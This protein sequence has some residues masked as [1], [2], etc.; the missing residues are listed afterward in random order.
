MEAMAVLSIVLGPCSF[1]VVLLHAM[2]RLPE[3]AV[4]MRLA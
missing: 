1:L 4:P 3:V 2:R